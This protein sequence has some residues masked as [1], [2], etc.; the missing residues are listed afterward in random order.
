METAKITVN[1][2]DGSTTRVYDAEAIINGHVDVAK[3]VQSMVEII[4]KGASEVNYL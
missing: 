4:I 3:E 2:P 1:L